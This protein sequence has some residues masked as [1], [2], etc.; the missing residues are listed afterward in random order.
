MKNEE[1][2]VEILAEMAKKLDQTIERQDRQ[3]EILLEQVKILS[4][5]VERQDRQEKIL[6]DHS[7]LLNRMVTVLDTV[8]ERLDVASDRVSEI[9]DLQRR[10]SRL[11]QHVGL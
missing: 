3:E 10:M 9:P 6:N 4:N 5:V 8:S 2:I 11:E 7:V 1:R